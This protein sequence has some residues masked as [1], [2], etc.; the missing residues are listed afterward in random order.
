M[1]VAELLAEAS[2]LR[3]SWSSPCFVA[4]LDRGSV[5]VYEVTSYNEL[6]DSYAMWRAELWNAGGLVAAKYG[7]GAVEAYSALV[8]ALP[9][10]WQAWLAQQ[11]GPTDGHLAHDLEC[12]Q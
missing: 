8:A 9:R 7:D 11:C 6:G 1:T 12:A 4:R 10:H 5:V 2:G 3:F